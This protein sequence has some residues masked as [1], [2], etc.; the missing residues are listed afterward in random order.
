MG[1][2]QRRSETGSSTPLY[3]LSAQ[4]T[5][6]VVGLGNVGKQYNRTRHN[7]GFE[8]I[9]A[10]AHHNN[11][12]DW[13]EKKDLKCFLT[14]QLLGDTTVILIKPSTYMNLSGEAVQAVQHYYKLAPGAIM[15]VHD[16]VDVSFGAIRTKFGGGDAGH[17][18]LKSVIQYSGNDFY[19]IRIGI[20]NDKMAA[21][22]LENFV[23]MA[24]SS[25]EQNKLPLI[26]KQ[27]NS[28]IKEFIE[29]STIAPRTIQIQQNT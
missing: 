26:Y 17:N 20:A 23:L 12:P 2:F 28:I 24:F 22:P 5:L 14:K 18:G 27:V 16:D 1:L 8:C 11:F 3:T 25:D 10:F 29:N 19:R 15:V 6:I 4:K 9:N 13:I 21:I 7:I